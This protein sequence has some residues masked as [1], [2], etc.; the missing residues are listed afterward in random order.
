MRQRWLHIL[1]A[2]AVFLVARATCCPYA[3]GDGFH[4]AALL[5]SSLD[6]WVSQLSRT[7][8]EVGE[9]L[10]SSQLK[11]GADPDKLRELVAKAKG[12]KNEGGSAASGGKIDAQ[13]SASQQ[14]VL[15]NLA[16]NDCLEILAYMDPQNIL[17]HEFPN[18]PLQRCGEFRATA[19]KLVRLMGE[20][21][22]AAVAQQL[23]AELLGSGKPSIPGDVTTTA[24]YHRDLL[25]LLRQGA[26]NGELSEADQQALDE[27][28]AAARGGPQA[29]LAEDV[30]EVLETGAFG[31]K[32]LQELVELYGGQATGSRKKRAILGAI[33]K[34]LGAATVPELA[35]IVDSKADRSVRAEVQKE[36]L[37]RVKEGTELDLV[38][39]LEA[40]ENNALRAE[41][42][43]ALQARKPR[44]AELEPQVPG[45]VK[46]LDAKNSK[47]T[48]AARAQL[49]R[50]F[51]IAPL[52]RCLAWLGR[53][54]TELDELIYGQLDVKVDRAQADRRRAYLQ[55]CLDVLQDAKAG[56]GAHRGALRVLGRLGD[57]AAVAPVVEVLPKLSRK[58]WPAAGQALEQITG[59]SFGP[60]E[61]DGVA[62]LTVARKRWQEWLSRQEKQ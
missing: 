5:T 13:L 6:E 2:A 31:D 21:G 15:A 34:R 16:A 46:L 60:K 42:E 62:E 41:V 58:V 56:E 30:K 32:S 25:D 11:A 7:V 39:M 1:C 22:T 10:G 40:C 26:E 19:K 36:L 35:E 38:E 49:E 37:R 33:R 9:A 23:R 59:M 14:Q 52:G 4:N 28:V 45:L 51:R 47:A 44:F 50:G 18:F 29:E 53:E 57:R 61:G 43:A 27:A 55:M 20:R 54:G 3:R 48:E 12:K 8:P 17:P 24:T